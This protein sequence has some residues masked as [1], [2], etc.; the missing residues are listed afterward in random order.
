MNKATTF[1]VKGGDSTL[2]SNPQHWPASVKPPSQW[3]VIGRS[4]L[5]PIVEWLPDDLRGRVMTLWPKVPVPPAIWE[6]Q[7]TLAQDHTGTAKQAQFVLGARIVPDEQDGAR[8][9]VQLVCG[10]AMTPELGRGDAAGGRASF[11]RN[12]P[13]DIRI[14][15]ASVCLPVPA[16]HNYAAATPDT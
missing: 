2:A 11:H 5:T 10:T 6:L 3:A 16:G 14:D 4:K 9:D 15:T 1:T 7:D 8:G 13:S 12:R